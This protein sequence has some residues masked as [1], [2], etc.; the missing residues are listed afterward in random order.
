[1]NI[2]C[3]GNEYIKN[4]KLAK[5]IADKIKIPNINFIK[6]NKIEDILDEKGTIYILDVMKGI[7][8]ITIIK[9]PDQL[10]IGK[11]VSC[12]DFDLGFFLKLLKKLN[13]IQYVVI[14]ALPMQQV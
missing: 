8:E 10:Y 4:D 12:H 3:F 6:C 11:K 7:N 1:M 14:I 5:E 2:Y 13:K 9:D